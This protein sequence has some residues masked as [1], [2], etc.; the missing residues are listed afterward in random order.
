MAG[1]AASS[2]AARLAFRLTGLYG[3]ARREFLDLR[4]REETFALAGLPPELDGLSNADWQWHG[5]MDF[6]AFHG[7][8]ANGNAALRV[9]PHGKGSYV[10]WQVPP[11]SIDEKSRP[12]LRTSKR[13]AQWML[14]RLA[15]NLGID[16]AAPDRIGYADIP[17]ADDD[18]YRYYRW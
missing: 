9:V 3:R 15:G 1:S 7:R 12:Y 8:P 6:D 14:A 10:F 16:L 2:S 5:S 11:E 18:P 4:L 17:E 13:R